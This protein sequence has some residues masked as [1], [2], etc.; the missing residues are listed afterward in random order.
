MMMWPPNGTGPSMTMPAAPWRGRAFVFWGRRLF[1]GRGKKQ[2]WGEQMEVYA[3]QG[4]M[5]G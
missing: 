3:M 2:T 4:G 1:E 5:Q